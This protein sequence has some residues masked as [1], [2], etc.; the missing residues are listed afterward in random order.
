VQPA[1]SRLWQG[2]IGQYN[3]F[4]LCTRDSNKLGSRLAKKMG[5][6]DWW[7]KLHFTGTFT[8]DDDFKN[9]VV[10][11]IVGQ[12]TLSISPR[13][14]SVLKE[15]GLSL[16]SL[17][18]HTQVFGREF[19]ET[20]L[21]WSIVTEKYIYSAKQKQEDDERVEGHKRKLIQA[22]EVLS[23][24]LM[25]LF[26]VKPEMLPNPRPQEAHAGVC[27]VLDNIWSSRHHGD[28]ERNSSA[29]SH[30]S[31]NPFHM[32]NEQFQRLNELFH[33]DGPN[34]SSRI[35]QRKELVSYMWNTGYDEKVCVP[36]FN[37]FLFYLFL[38][39]CTDFCQF[40]FDGIDDHAPVYIQLIDL[41]HI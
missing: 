13:G 17:D 20:I 40:Q 33:Q 25:F 18:L 27:S 2:S 36:S 23:N 9:L 22:I 1:R 16:E 8:P 11:A 15:K 34:A 3:L 31:W 6:E 4:H 7:N 12:M 14:T 41:Q 32:L 30:K 10:R 26:V 28:D 39:H 21:I 5:L 38:S 24:Y 29:V 37:L 19:N 35:K